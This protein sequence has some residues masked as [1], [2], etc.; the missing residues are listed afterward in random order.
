MFEIKRYAPSDKNL[1]NQFL[2]KAKNGTFLFNRNYMDYH[3]DRF[4]DHSMVIL[5]HDHVFALLPANIKDSVLYSHQG[6][7]YGGLITDKHATIE[8]IIILF[9]EL[10]DHLRSE[11]ITRVVY[12][13]LPWIYHRIP[14]EEDLYALTEV[15]QAR[16]IT[17]EIS[18]TI[19]LQH[20]LPFQ[21]S[22]KSGLR[23][24]RHAG[25]TVKES[26]DLET[27]WT[28][29]DNNLSAR[30]HTH[31]V[32]TCAELQLLKSRFPKQIRLFMAY[33][34]DTALGGT[35]I[36]DTGRVIHTQ[37]ISA[38]P[39]GK[40]VGAL[41]LIFDKV[42]HEEY[43]DRTIFDFG[44]STEDHGHYLNQSLIFQK[45]GFGGR[46]VVYDTYEWEL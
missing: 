38:T 43:Q 4:H 37:Y 20:Q 12:K 32:H 7:T 27:F 42:L 39:E 44:K 10:N 1:W 40:A 11:G 33:Q 30:Y 35:L 6:L 36:Y 13:A 16:L 3:A 18:S 23:K 25:L 2:E 24:A 14:A 19:F 9:Q 41:D 15:C 46:G 29:L 31:P 34:G 22:R 45:E 26:D 28:I 21:E 8:K 17:R 5:Y